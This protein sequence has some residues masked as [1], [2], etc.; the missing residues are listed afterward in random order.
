MIRR[1]LSFLV[2]MGL[3]IP[4][5]CLSSPR[6]A[7]YQTEGFTYRIQGDWDDL[8]AAVI[9]GAWLS[10]FAVVDEGDPDA[11]RRTFELVATNDEPASLTAWQDGDDVV[12][13]A[14]VGRFG[15]L[16]REKYL[17]QT[18]GGRLHELRGRDAAPLRGYP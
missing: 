3:A 5:G 7:R 14:H 4:A 17:A 1:L 2:L 12:L 9:A 6:P 11:P 8:D 18:V 16:N 15:D 10:E 13:L